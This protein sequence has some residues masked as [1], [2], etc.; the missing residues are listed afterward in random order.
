MAVS[1]FEKQP[2]ELNLE[3]FVKLPFGIGYT[4]CDRPHVM[5]GGFS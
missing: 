4:I 1:F 5:I 2:E 3:Y